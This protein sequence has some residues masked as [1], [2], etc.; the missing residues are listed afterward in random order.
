MTM[1]RGTRIVSGREAAILRQLE[2]RFRSWL[3]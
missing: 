3:H 2:N 1:I